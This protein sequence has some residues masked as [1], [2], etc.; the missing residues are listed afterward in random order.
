MTSMIGTV[1][2]VGKKFDYEYDFG[3]TTALW[4]EATGARVGSA[5]KKP[6]RLLARNDRIVWP[7]AKCKSPATIICPF[8]LDDGAC[9]FCDEHAKAHA[10]QDQDVYLP[11]V[12]SPRMGVCGYTGEN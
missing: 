1:F 3:S 7:C 5:G 4:G 6:V 2:A 11:V 9:L 12:N 8:C 10:C